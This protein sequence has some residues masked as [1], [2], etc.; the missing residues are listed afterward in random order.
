MIF[1]MVLG[2]ILGTYLILALDAFVYPGFVV[3]NLQINPELVLIGCLIVVFLGAMKKPSSLMSKFLKINK[4][5]FPLLTILYLFFIYLEN[6][7]FPNYVFSRFH[8]DPYAF[9]Y[10]PLLSGATT[11]AFF[12]GFGLKKPFYY[13]ILP[14]TMVVFWIILHTFPETYRML[15][16]EDGPLEYLQFFLYLISAVYAF[17]IFLHFK[18]IPK[19]K[20]YAILFLLLSLGLLF[21]AKEEISWGQRLLGIETPE[22]I[23]EINAQD[24]ITIHNLEIFQHDILHMSFMF[25]GLY[26]AFSRIIA[27]KL[28]PKSFDKLKIFTPRYEYFFCFFSAFA[29]Y[30]VL[31]YYL[32][33]NEIRVGVFHPD[34]LQEVFETYLAFG[35]FGYVRETFKGLKA[36]A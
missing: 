26:G 7:H 16:V 6:R 4:F 5:L 17:R 15:V 18:K 10:L 14:V 12:K 8:V 9:G 21:V 28:F 13:L 33:P 25:V 1:I 36:K 19:K 3:N 2:I 34:R 31:D 32:V 11:L 29:Y 24:E 27:K 30:F 35:F 23:A 22:A 20:V